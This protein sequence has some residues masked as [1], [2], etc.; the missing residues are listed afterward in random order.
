MTP[1][2]SRSA[3][4]MNSQRTSTTMTEEADVDRR[5]FLLFAGLFVVGVV[6]GLVEL[7]T[8]RDETSTGADVATANWIHAGI[9]AVLITLLVVAYVRDRRR[10]AAFLVRPLTAAGWVAM[11]K[12]LTDLPLLI[13]GRRRLGTALRALAGFVLAVLI[14]LMVLRAGEQVFAALD[15]D[16]TRDAWGGPS[17]L[18]ASLAHWM[19]GAI[20]FYAFFAVL[21]RTTSGR[22]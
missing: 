4:A 3:T 11:K 7:L 2:T 14:A 9:A 18:G 16:F 17:Y 19:D 21:R 15:P 1:R 12:G 22:R 20:L 8:N 13:V 6:V 10:L 5:A